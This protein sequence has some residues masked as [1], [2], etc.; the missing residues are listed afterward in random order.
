MERLGENILS[1]P[2]EESD[3]HAGLSAVFR[4]EGYVRLPKL[5]S[6]AAWR[7]LLDQSSALATNSI[8]RD[9]VMPG[10][11]TPRRMRSVGG[12]SIRNSG[13]QLL[14]LYHHPE[15][16]RLI[17]SV[18]GGRIYSSNHEQEFMV[19]NVFDRE[20]ATHGWHFDDPPIALV[21]ILE[22]PPPEGG[23]QLEFVSTEARQQ[24]DQ[25]RRCSGL[26]GFLAAS[27]ENGTFRQRHHEAGD[28][29]LLRADRCLHRVVPI[30]EGSRRA[31]LNLAFQLSPQL[32]YGDTADLLYQDPALP[33]RA[34]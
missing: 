11:A 10:Y 22:A 25:I 3:A 31:V 34:A 29:Y 9:F 2:Y 16:R 8:P 19:M 26:A 18:V 28:A 20:G 24:R 7:V 21:V 27:R 14:A 15:L 6:K 32:G 33:A 5:F 30:T 4:D 23:G 17:R 13:E 12:K 1:Q